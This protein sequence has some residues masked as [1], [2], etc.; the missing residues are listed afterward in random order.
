MSAAS[1]LLYIRYDLTTMSHCQQ[2]LFWAERLCL[3]VDESGNK[4][5][6]ASDGAAVTEGEAN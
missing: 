3:F 4:F 6:K 5:P 2:R 1:S